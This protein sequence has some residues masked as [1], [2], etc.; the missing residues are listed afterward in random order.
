MPLLKKPSSPLS[1]I[2]VL[3]V[4]KRSLLVLAVSLFT[5]CALVSAA[6]AAFTF[7]L[8]PNLDQ[9][10]PRLEQSLSGALGHRVSISA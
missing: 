3:R 8:L 7:W 10:R 5:A 4:L 9:Y 6:F 1:H 2:H